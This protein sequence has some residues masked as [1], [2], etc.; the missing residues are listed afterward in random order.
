M[1]VVLVREDS[2]GEGDSVVRES[3][4]V[5]VVMVWCC[6]EDSVGE[7]GQWVV[8]ESVLVSG[9]DGWGGGGEDSVGEGDSGG[10]GEC[11]G[12]VVVMVVVLVRDSVGE[13]D[14]GW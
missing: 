11:V 5:S 10:E 14:S 1:V 4:L 6:E 13:G 3:V 2:V 7:G 9:G 8:R 12:L